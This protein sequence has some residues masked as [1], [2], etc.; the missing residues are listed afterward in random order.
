[1]LGRA[2]RCYGDRGW[3]SAGGS[4]ALP[5]HPP[6]TGG[7]AQPGEEKSRGGS[8]VCRAAHPPPPGTPNLSAPTELLGEGGL[9]V[10]VGGCELCPPGSPGRDTERSGR[11]GAGIRSLRGG[12]GAATPAFAKRLDMAGKGG[13]GLR[14]GGA[15]AAAPLPQPLAPRG[16]L[17]HGTRCPLRAAGAAGPWGHPGEMRWLGILG[18]GFC[19][20][21]QLPP[22]DQGTPD[23]PRPPVGPARAGAAADLWVEEQHL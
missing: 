11:S 19:D 9:G 22:P 14:E 20:T 13:L 18:T 23:W 21:H 3:G 7:S 1:M 16:S 15:G 2:S 12:A 4:T 10:D 5:Q 17:S 8:H 6:D